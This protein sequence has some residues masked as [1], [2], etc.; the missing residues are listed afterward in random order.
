MELFISNLSVTC[1]L[2]VLTLTHTECAH[3]ELFAIDI[4]QNDKLDLDVKCYYGMD[5]YG[6]Y[7]EDFTGLTIKLNNISLYTW[8]QSAGETPEL[9]RT[10][11]L[12]LE[13]K[14]QKGWFVIKNAGVN[15]LGLYQCDIYYNC[16]EEPRELV[17]KGGI[18]VWMD[19]HNQVH[20]SGGVT[21]SP[22][23]TDP[24]PTEPN[25]GQIP[26]I[27]STDTPSHIPVSPPIPDISDM[28][29]ISGMC[30]IT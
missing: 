11:G 28:N 1:L 25:I 4:T 14:Q 3:I 8:D 12:D 20:Q 2:V 21:D 10:S 23:P 17:M 9:N 27:L 26:P 18:T 24:P 29:V 16:K 30:L 22:F 15:A 13:P 5:D 7:Y 6:T 19:E